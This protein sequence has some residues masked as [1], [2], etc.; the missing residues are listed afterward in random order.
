LFSNRFYSK[1]GKTQRNL[2]INKKRLKNKL[3]KQSFQKKNSTEN[4]CIFGFL[5]KIQVFGITKA[6]K[7][8][9]K[10][11]REKISF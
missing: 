7:R 11:K 9:I 10:R 2:G 3:K 6:K 1:P 5:H 4:S 8:E